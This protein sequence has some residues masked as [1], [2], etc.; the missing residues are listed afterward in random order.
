MNLRPR[1]L[2]WLTLA[3]VL[4]GGLAAH[5]AP[6][7]LVADPADAARTSWHQ[8]AMR[9]AGLDHNS[10]NPE[11]LP[12]SAGADCRLVVI[13]P[14][15]N[16][17]SS[18]AAAWLATFVARGGRLIVFAP[19][20]SALQHMF[21]LTGSGG[22]T[23]GSENTIGAVRFVPDAEGRWPER[24]AQHTW[25]YE[26]VVARSEERVL[27]WWQPP[28]A[29]TG[30]GAA[31]PTTY[32]AV[33]SAPAGLFIAAAFNGEDRATESHLLLA[34]AT[35]FF[36]D[37]WH[38]AM[39]VL[40]N[41]AGA[42]ADL[43]NLEAL[44]NRIAGAGLSLERRAAARRELARAQGL[45]QAARNGYAEG[46]VIANLPP[47]PPT[48]AAE[49]YIPPARSAWLANEAAE[50]AY[51]LSLPSIP[52]EF[53][54]AW[55][56]NAGGIREW[57]WPR[58]LEALAAGGIENVFINVANGGYANYPSK[59]LPYVTA[60]GED[61]LREAIAE[62][63]RLGIRVHAWIM[64]TFMRP[65]TPIE[66]RRQMSSEGR[67]Q[68]RADGT[69]G[70][71]LSPVDER[72]RELMREVCR[73]LAANYDLDGVHL[74]Y[75]RFGTA[76]LGFGAEEREAF[77][78]SILGPVTD[79]PREVIDRGPTRAQFESWRARNVDR[80]VQ[81]MSEGARE[82]RPGIQVSAAVYPI[83]V[84][85]Y[86]QV[87]QHPDQ[88][89]ENGWVDF[90]TPMNYHTN[91]K[92]F[93]DYFGVQQ[94]AAGDRVPLYAGIAA[95]R[96]ETPAATAYQIQQL[97]ELGARGW[98]LFHL[99]QYLADQVLPLLRLG[100]TAPAN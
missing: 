99:D 16:E 80:L 39:P 43:P 54:G 84:D 77:E 48:T 1:T 63:R 7:V 59:V 64:T 57:G 67:L 45:L 28:R 29:T 52:G 50:M 25:Q 32:P 90:I 53:S 26:I 71:W 18:A 56:Q 2:R 81:A 6:V 3:C 46:L 65:L 31:A 47:P 82:G 38:Q 36:P 60:E 44:S 17:L 9:R 61:P 78:R 98:A 23:S 72:N 12:T 97:R 15:T 93:R 87:G 24:W 35:E 22:L 40:L 8:R 62:C 83:W 85:A 66:W 91:D 69:Y 5:A 94:R 73:E 4:V 75:V 68:G 21:G 33:V 100:I 96:M 95:W 74:D 11:Q 55:I 49:R 76:D 79:W 19:A 70:Y 30:A 13:A 27:G 34:A 51:C 92:S 41:R 14:Q 86:H 88:W 58:T 10:L 20:P 42:V 37:L 89:A